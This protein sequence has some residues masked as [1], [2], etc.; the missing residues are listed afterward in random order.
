MARSK[1]RMVYGD[2]LG[3]FRP[4]IKSLIFNIL[5]AK[6][7]ETRRAK[8]PFQPEGAK[9]RLP[10]EAIPYADLTYMAV[11]KSGKV[12]EMI[13]VNHETAKMLTNRGVKFVP[14]DPKDIKVKKGMAFVD[15]TFVGEQNEEN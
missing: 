14:F 15:G 2:L 12:V 1:S 6:F 5:Y 10:E 8:E 7:L 9:F 13:R 4:T 11:V 3:E